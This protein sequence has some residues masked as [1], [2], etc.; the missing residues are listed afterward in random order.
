MKINN[1]P[2]TQD[3]RLENGGGEID[4]KINFAQATRDFH[5]IPKAPAKQNSRPDDLFLSYFF[6][7]LS[8]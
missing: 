7:F 1:Q 6:D 3:V 8:L 2:V 4:A 5:G